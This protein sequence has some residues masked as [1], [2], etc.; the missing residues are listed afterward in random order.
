MYTP[1]QPNFNNQYN[2]YNPMIQPNPASSMYNATQTMGP[3]LTFVNGLD[4][5]KAFPTQPNS[6]VALF[7]ENDDIMYIKTT[8]ASNFPTIKRYRFIEEKE[9]AKSPSETYVTIEEFNQFKEEIMNAQQSISAGKP[10]SNS[11]SKWNGKQPATNKE[12]DG[13]NQEQ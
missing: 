3:Q 12:Y 10:N 7:D 5:A 1:Y 13:S 2:P 4:S 9:S 11:K 6:R 8:D